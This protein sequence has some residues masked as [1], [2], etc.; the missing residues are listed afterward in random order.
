MKPLRPEQ[1]DKLP[2]ELQV[3]AINTERTRGEKFFDFF[4]YKVINF[5]LN[6]LLSLA[7]VD[8][9]LGGTPKVAGDNPTSFFAQKF[10]DKGRKVS[11]NLKQ[12]QD[13]LDKKAG[14][15]GGAV[16][17]LNLGGH[18][19]A[20]MV[21]LLEN[22]R[23]ELSRRFDSIIDYFTGTKANATQLEKRENRYEILRNTPTKTGWQVV[24]GRAAGM[25]ASMVIN[26]TPEWIDKKILKNTPT[27]GHYGFRRMTGWAG[28][29]TEPAFNGLA[30]IFKAGAK[31]EM[32]D[33]RVKYWSE[34]ILFETWCTGITSKVME[35][36]IKWGDKNHVPT[37]TP[38]VASNSTASPTSKPTGNRDSNALAD[39]TTS[40]FSEETSEDKTKWRDR[41]YGY[42][43]ED[44]VGI[45]HNV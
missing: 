35:K 9:F 29:K 18:I 34:V 45:G 33:K 16:F 21:K 32:G 28:K 12:F 30:K 40:R 3:A 37:D 15:T 24:K 23:V 1:Q 4:T 17:T 2:K 10:G 6:E 44:Q 22:R 19:T 36:V 26:Q 13:K 31:N 42:D 11:D 14:K 20:G 5:G 8:L 43:Y 39:A 41:K 27:N 7:I 38:T 25:L